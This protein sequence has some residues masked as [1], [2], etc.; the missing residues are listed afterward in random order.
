MNIDQIPIISTEGGVFTPEH[1]TVIPKPFSRAT[2]AFGQP[3]TIFKRTAKAIDA[4][5]NR[6]AVLEQVGEAPVNGG[7]R[8]TRQL[9]VDDRA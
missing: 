3:V 7:R 4:G 9:L 8:A 2:I 5:R 1:K 6:P